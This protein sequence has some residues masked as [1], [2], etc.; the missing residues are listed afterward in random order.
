MSKGS[1][2]KD[3]WWQVVGSQQDSIDGMSQ[4]LEGSD[5]HAM[6]REEDSEGVPG[7]RNSTGKGTGQTAAFSSPQTSH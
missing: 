7:G 1:V 2:A 6:G 4:R 3:G 5:R